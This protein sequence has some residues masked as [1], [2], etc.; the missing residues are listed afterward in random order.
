[1]ARVDWS[2]K[3]NNKKKPSKKNRKKFKA[4]KKN[5]QQMMNSDNVFIWTD[6][7]VYRN[8]SGADGGFAFLVVHKQVTE[9]FYGYLPSGATNN[10]A[11][12]TAIL[13][14]LEKVLENGLQEKHVIVKTDSQYSINCV[15]KWAKK[16]EANGWVTASGS[17]VKNVE[18]IKEIVTAKSF[19]SNIEFHWVRGHSGIELNER[20]DELAS[21]AITDGRDCKI[22]CNVPV[23]LGAEGK[24]NTVT[25][26]HK[27][28]VIGMNPSWEVWIDYGDNCVDYHSGKFTTLSSSSEKMALAIIYAKKLH[29]KYKIDLKEN[30]SQ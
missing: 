30:P 17:P 26:Y 10:I 18:L 22:L 13:R 12:L 7:A 15:T 5:K 29:E 9:P 6:G 1:M 25:V 16:W 28:S 19:F 20:A 3:P 21:Q 23:C 2:Y 24:V 11:E 14:G 27:E 4:A 8:G